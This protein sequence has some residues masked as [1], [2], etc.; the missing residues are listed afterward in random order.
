MKS[1]KKKVLFIALG[2]VALGTVVIAAKSVQKTFKSISL[3]GLLED[4]KDPAGM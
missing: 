4:P 3:T 1:N 2:L